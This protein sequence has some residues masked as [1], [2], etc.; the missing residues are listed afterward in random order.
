MPHPSPVPAAAL[1][2]SLALAACDA[3]PRIG[4]APPQVSGPAPALLPLE[5]IL[6][7]SDTAA[8]ASSDPGPA[9]SARAAALRARAAAMRGAVNDPA[10]RSRLTEAAG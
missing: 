8:T 4:S 3:A 1:L 9:L 10:T 7:A 2:L 5:G 6:Q